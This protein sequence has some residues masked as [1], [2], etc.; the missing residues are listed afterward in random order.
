M[1]CDIEVIF[2]DL[3]N[4]LRVL[5][6]DE[7]HQ[8]KARQQIA[9]LLET[10][11]S[12]EGL[13]E[14]L[15]A[16][17]KAY[18]K[19][20]FEHLTESPE[21]ELWTRWLA[22]EFPAEKVAPLA[23]QLTYE[24]RQSM[25]RR[26]VQPGAREV[27]E[28]LLRRGYLLGIISNVITSREIPD[29]LEADGYAHYF[30]SVVLSS[31]FGRR[32]PDPSI[33]FEA[34]RIAD[35]EPE[36]CVYVGDNPKRDVIGTR[37]AGFGMAI[38]M[39]DPAEEE[40]EPPSGENVPDRVIHN[41]SDLLDVFP[42]RGIIPEYEKTDKPNSQRGGGGEALAAKVREL[43][44]QGQTDYSLEPII[45][46]DDQNQPLGRIQDGDAVIFCCRRGDRE[47][48]L[49]EAFV[50]KN[51][52]HF[53][54]RELKDLTFVILTLYHEKFK[55]L[56]VAFAPIDLQDTLGETV[57][58]AQLRQLRIAESEKFAHV[59]F[60]F[61]GNRHTSFT[62]EVD[63]RVPSPKG[64][65]FD[66]APELSLEQVTGKVLH[67]IHQQ[68]D[69]IVANFANGDVIGH[70]QNC[71]AKIRC[72]E[73]VDAR[74]GQVVKA[75]VA[76]DYVVLVTADHGNLEEMTHA[77]GTPH[78]AHTTNLVPFIWID[79]RASQIA[80]DQPGN[81]D[82]RIPAEGNLADIAPTILGALGV[83]KP[84]AM[85]GV[86]LTPEHNWAGSRRVLLVILDGWGLGRQDDSNP[87]FLAH[88]P[89]W[90]DLVQHYP[91]RWLQASG[92][93]VGLQPG[94]PGNSEAGHMNIGAGRVV[95]QDD[96]RLDLALQDGS[97]S[98]NETFLRTIKAVKQCKTNLHLIGL[99]TERSSHGSIEY[100]LALLQM[101]KEKG[102]EKVYIHVIFDGRSTEPGSAPAMLEKLDQQVA[103]IGVGQIVSGVGR[104]FALDRDRNH[105]KVQRAYDALVSGIG[106]YVQHKDAG[107]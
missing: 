95:V 43:Y 3:G 13:C 34:A 22:P 74:L 71:Q 6:K 87:I 4:T 83:E 33:Y 99:L 58:R 2:L 89:T 75:A 66:Q 96:V 64:I 8:S 98:R 15:D 88:T 103:E 53:P 78:V 47:I 76:A 70:T 42:K 45:L 90:D 105:A 18:R 40:A 56:P 32:K 84:P 49:T 79:P 11:E 51:F 65:P 60:F 27:L 48:Q 38:L 62:G 24:Y 69:L 44:N 46:V 97:F 36:L 50:E 23:V 17:Y 86:N 1:P 30:K 107:E 94:K 67:G 72:A 93:A 12:P 63:W 5:V 80:E 10:S 29:W 102:L 35:V 19:W 37:R 7:A 81:I 57:S 14:R 92:E 61:N 9:T 55:D 104:G 101:A 77:D 28:E 16:R 20:A 41:F 59:T 26:V 21:A 100:P 68:Y 39:L 82:A 73:L 31:V 106:H 25:G 54:R 85:Q 91:I 52:A